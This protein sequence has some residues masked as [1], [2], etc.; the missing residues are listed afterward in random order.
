[1]Y[2]TTLLHTKPSSNCYGFRNF[3]VF[4]VFRDQL[5]HFNGTIDIFKNERQAKVYAQCNMPN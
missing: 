5:M 3:V 1:M 4:L 2:Q